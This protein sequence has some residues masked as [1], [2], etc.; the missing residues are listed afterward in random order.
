MHL[1]AALVPPRDALEQVHRLAAGVQPGRTPPAE[2]GRPGR[3]ASGSSGKRFGRRRDRD[4]PPPR[5]TGP[6]LDLLPSVQMH[7]PIAKFGNLAHADSVRLG[8]T[9][10]VQA[11]TWESPR[12]HLSGGVAMKPEDDTAVWVGVAGDIEALHAVT[13]GVTAVAQGLQLFVDRRVFRPHVQLGTTN[14]RSTPEYLE[15]LVAELEA[16][17]ST[18]WWQTTVSLLSPA[19]LG[20]DKPPYKVIGE[21]T[22]GPAVGH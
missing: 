7:L 9:M 12:L 10:E 21:F 6:L 17:E 22:L 13:R 15:Q 4:T 14:P 8:D 1:Y 3:H 20:P 5:P 18:S 19:D 2:S 11:K 16:F